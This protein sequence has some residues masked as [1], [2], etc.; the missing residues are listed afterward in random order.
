MLQHLRRP[1][2]K[3]MFDR[4]AVSGQSFDIRPG[5]LEIREGDIITFEDPDG[6]EITRRIDTVLHSRDLPTVAENTD[7]GFFVI[8]LAI[9]AA[10][11]LES[12]FALGGVVF[13]FALERRSGTTSFKQEPQY[14]PVLVCDAVDPEVVL[15]ALSIDTWPD[16]C[17]SV[18]VAAK[19][20][21]SEAGRQTV[22]IAEYTILAL[23]P[24]QG[25]DVFVE[26]DDRLLRIGKLRDRFGQ[27]L[28][29][30]F[31][32]NVPG[33]DDA[34]QSNLELDPATLDQVNAIIGESD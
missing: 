9:S 28:E 24:H 23:A 17:F 34:G 30:Y 20:G 32:Q 26:V 18:L 11:I 27:H 12:A 10:S 6:R 13:G 7:Q 21:A 16:G 1:C 22:E 14:L 31:G 5:N 25:V 4:L 19:L 2:T 29:P 15:N 33:E 8:G 3:E